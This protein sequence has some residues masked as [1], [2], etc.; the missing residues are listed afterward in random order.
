MSEFKAHNIW[1]T[2]IYENEI[3]V[4]DEWLEFCKVVDCKRTNDDNGFISLG[5]HVLDNIVL[6]EL[7]KELIHHVSIFTKHQLNIV[8]KFKMTSSWVTKHEKGDFAQ[9]H[10]HKNSLISGVYYLQTTNNCG[11]I[12]FNRDH[13]LSESFMFDLQEQTMLNS[14]RYKIPV[15]TGKLLIFP[16]TVKHGTPKMPIDNFERIAIS[17]NMFLTGTVG[18]EDCLLQA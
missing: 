4:K 9:I 14:F 6:Q 1:P 16:S 7:K 18:A 3:L 17:F 11:D 2:P 15:E 10:S 5:S 8:N 12:I 13:F